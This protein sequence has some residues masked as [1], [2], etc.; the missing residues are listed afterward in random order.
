MSADIDKP[1]VAPPCTANSCSLIIGDARFR[2]VD[3][4]LYL[5]AEEWQG[6]PL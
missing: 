4:W 6:W 3:D 5:H 2:L 1:D